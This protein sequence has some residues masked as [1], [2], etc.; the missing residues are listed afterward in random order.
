LIAVESEGSV[1]VAIGVLVGLVGIVIG[2]TVGAWFYQ[3]RQD[4]RE[5]PPAPVRL[6][7]DGPLDNTSGSL[8]RT[9]PVK[10]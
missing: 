10:E 5:A 8:A 7:T 3:E 6:N 4:L 1:L 9:S 2:T